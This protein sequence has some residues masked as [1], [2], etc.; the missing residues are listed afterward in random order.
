LRKVTV[1]E[2]GE[3][4]IV[5][6]DKGF[7][8]LELL[9]SITLVAT[10]V[11]IATGALRLG[12]RSISS[13]EKKMESLERFRSSLYIIN[14]QISSAIPLSFDR[15]GIK[16][17]YFAGSEDFV[18]MATNY[19]IWGGQRG[20]V[21]VEYRVAIENNGTRSLYASENLVGTEKPRE[22]KLL[23]G[24]NGIYFEYFLQD[25]TEELGGKWISQWSDTTTVPE[26]IRLRLIQGRKEIS[27]TIPMRAR[28]LLQPQAY[29]GPLFQGETRGQAY[30]V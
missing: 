28:G 20:H 27:L 29:L 7:T 18:R 14:S 16:Q 17:V 15:Q 6:S 3:R 8:L 9:I 26:K 2:D 11:A 24:L 21:I 10:I 12:Y 25:R 23:Q 4:N 1:D 13:G 5:W 22:T 19:S 30:A